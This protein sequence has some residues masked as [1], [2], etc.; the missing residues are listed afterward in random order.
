MISFSKG[1]SLIPVIIFLIILVAGSIVFLQYMQEQDLPK[2][3]Q[4]A[5]GKFCGGIAG[6]LPEF[7]CPPGYYCKLE[8]DYPDAGGVCVK[9]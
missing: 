4:K 3:N 1:N 6:N 9:Q 2:S 5:D 8:G 7:Q